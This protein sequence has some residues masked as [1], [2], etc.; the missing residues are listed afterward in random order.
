LSV[1]IAIKVRPISLS[2]C[3]VSLP[4]FRAPLVLSQGDFAQ[5]LQRLYS[6]AQLNRKRWASGLPIQEMVVETDKDAILAYDEK[7]DWYQMFPQWKRS[8]KL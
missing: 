5:S 6:V 1:C 8:A 4:V 3:F 2:F 7:D